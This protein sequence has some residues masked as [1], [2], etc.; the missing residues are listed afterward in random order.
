MF[1]I[2]QTATLESLLDY[3]IFVI[4]I[5]NIFFLNIIKILLIYIFIYIDTY[6]I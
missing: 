3:S 1:L 5:I 4:I 6:N 2:M